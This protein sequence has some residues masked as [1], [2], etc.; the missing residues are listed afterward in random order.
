MQAEVSRGGPEAVVRFRAEASRA[1]KGG[2]HS[3]AVAA[4]RKAL[5]AI[6]P[7][8]G[9]AGRDENAARLQLLV[10]LSRSR[11]ALGQAREAVTDLRKAETTMAALEGAIPPRAIET[12]RAAVLA[13]SGVALAM[14][15]K[16]DEAE[17][18]FATGLA[19]IDRL[20][21]PELSGLRTQVLSAW[22]G[23][24]KSAGREADAKAML[25]AFGSPSRHSHDAACGCGHDHAHGSDH[26]HHHH[27]A[28]C[29]C[30]DH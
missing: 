4:F 22:E 11:L 13:N 18:A 19:A 17:S 2:R 1:Q 27:D 20:G 28:A 5:A 9:T 7:D 10:H 29:G 14:L 3:D 24:L 16:L 6:P 8:V 12:V 26:S 15:G 23:A 25:A 21:T 30:G